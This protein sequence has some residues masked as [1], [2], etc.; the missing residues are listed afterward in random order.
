MT[1][2][3]VLMFDYDGVIVDSF[4][5][6]KDAFLDSCRNN[7]CLTI[8]SDEE[9][10]KLFELNFYDGMRQHKLSEKEIDKI[11]GGMNALIL[12]RN[13]TYNFFDG[14][15]DALK[16]LSKENLLYI[17]TSNSSPA[18]ES[19][20]KDAELK[21]IEEVLGS[22]KGKSKIE[23]INSVVNRHKEIKENWYIGDTK[24][25]ILEGNE[26]GV[27]TL[28]VSWGWHTLEQL[29]EAI[30]YH[31]VDEPNELVVLFED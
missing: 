25:D 17:I 22:D 3:R 26:A 12:E 29:E 9:F 14:I 11:I 23:K 30:P 27:D 6:F 2:K 10:K 16:E 24:G 18:V 15:T 8:N 7:N 28:A 31:I 21:C 20:I 4:D 1:A 5:Y 19:F 13:N